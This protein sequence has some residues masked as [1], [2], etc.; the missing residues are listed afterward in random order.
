MRAPYLQGGGDEMF[1]M[2]EDKGFKY[3][4]SEPSLAYGHKYLDYG[5]Y[6]YTLDFKNDMDCQV[7]PC[8]HCSFPGIW[9][10]PILDFEDGRIGQ[11]PNDPDHGYPCSM[12]DTCMYV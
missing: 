9:V 11:N 7:E 10:Q 8:S 1:M 2:M 5:R 6:P 12:T 4:C 3:D